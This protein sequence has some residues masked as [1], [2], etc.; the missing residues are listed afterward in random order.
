MH[1]QWRLPPSRFA[2]RRRSNSW[3]ELGVD[4]LI[5]GHVGPKAFT[6]LEAGRVKIYTGA[7]GTLAHAIEQFKAGRLIALES[8]DVDGHWQ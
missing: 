2:R 7:G 5:T 8:A 3:R 6:T 1:S 4:G